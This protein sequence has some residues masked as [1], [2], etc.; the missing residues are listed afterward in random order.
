MRLQLTKKYLR[1]YFTASNSK[2][3]GIH[4]PFVFD[5]VKNVMKLKI[6]QYSTSVTNDSMS[7]GITFMSYSVVMI[8]LGLAAILSGLLAERAW[9]GRETSRGVAIAM[10]YAVDDVTDAFADEVI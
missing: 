5:F 9:R 7:Q 1:Y 10:T 8:A 4:S 3:H 6:S 2:G